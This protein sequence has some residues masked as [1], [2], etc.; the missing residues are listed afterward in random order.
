M[1]I[2]PSMIFGST[3]TT[4]WQA[5]TSVLV[6]VIMNKK[7]MFFCCAANYLLRLSQCNGVARLKER[8]Y[9]ITAVVITIQL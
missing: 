1:C 6:H 9:A 7:C 2:A 3:V 5:A 4:I 8:P